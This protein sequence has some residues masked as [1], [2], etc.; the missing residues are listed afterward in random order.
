MAPSKKNRNSEC[1]ETRLLFLPFHIPFAWRPGFIKRPAVLSNFFK[2]GA[3]DVKTIFSCWF[4]RCG[5]WNSGGWSR[6]RRVAH[7]DGNRGQTK[8]VGLRNCES[9]QDLQA[10]RRFLPVR[11]GR[12][13][14]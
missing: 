5:Y 1:R 3:G 14:E 4:D 11:H 12:L 9:R 13:D 8:C 10:L 7:A 2:T 6:R